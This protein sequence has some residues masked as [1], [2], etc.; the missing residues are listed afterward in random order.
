VE[1]FKSVHAKKRKE[2]NRREE[3]KMVPFCNLRCK[4]V[5]MYCEEIRSEDWTGLIDLPRKQGEKI[6]MVAPCIDNIEPFI[7]QLMHKKL[8]KILNY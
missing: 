3:N 6:F 4:G 8:R 5:K 2:A 1:R 7:V